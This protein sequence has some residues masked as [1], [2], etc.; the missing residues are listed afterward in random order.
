MRTNIY[1]W[2]C[3]NPL[4]VE[5]KLVYNDKYKLADITNTVREIAIHHFK[6]KPIKVESTGSSGNHYTYHIIYP[7]R[8][9]FFR[10]DD[11]KIDDDYMDAEKAAMNLARQ[12]GVPVPEIYATDTSRKKF[13][14]RYQ[15]MEKVTGESMKVFYQDGTLEKEKVSREVGRHL[16][17]MHAIKLDGFGFFNT[18]VLR[19]KNK[20][21][22]LD[23][24]NKQYFDKK[25]QYHLKYLQDTTFLT[26]KEVKEIE[27][28][29]HKF[30]KHLDIQQGY[31]VHKDVAY[32]NMVGTPQ[33]VNAIV[34]WDDVISGD[35][36]DDLAV[37]R[38]FYGEDVFNPL[39]EG[40][41]E[42]TSLPDDFYPRLWL[43]LIRNML[44][45]AVFRI[46]MKYMDMDIKVSLLNRS[47]DK[48]LREFTYNQLYLGINGLKNL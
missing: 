44:W 11:G 4:S 13:P 17:K 20:I 41:K 29:I 12:H 46:F 25:L 18:E 19:K 14:V 2:K 30:K 37:E 6:K 33:K 35:P 38:C 22:G 47:K 3:D 27:K 32:W 10:S 45:K 24:T 5:E 39:I 1:Y 9:I 34:D 36:I 23:K 48:S 15:L 43:Y 31:M 8:T 26:G 7:D 16:A 40:Y 28:L 42:I 21:V